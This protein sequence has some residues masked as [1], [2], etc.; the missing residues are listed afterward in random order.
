MQLKLF[1]EHPEKR[2]QPTQNQ[3]D[4]CKYQDSVANTLPNLIGE[5]MR[6]TCKFDDI[7]INFCHDIVC[8]DKIIETKNV[9]EDRPTEDWFFESSVLQC[10][11]YQ[12][13]LKLSDGKVTTAEFFVRQGHERVEKE[14]NTNL[15]YYLYFGEDKYLVT[16]SNPLAIANFIL[17]KARAATDWNKAREFDFVYKRKEFETLKKYFTY[18]KI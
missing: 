4:G 3:F 10:A 13:L 2:P 14:I 7:F 1:M 16:V 5:E 12:S 18:E 15:P 11:V 6:S 9:K 8:E 17:E